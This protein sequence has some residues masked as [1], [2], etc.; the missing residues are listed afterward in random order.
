MKKDQKFVLMFIFI[1]IFFLFNSSILFPQAGRGKA[2]LSGE[3]ENEE[4]NSIP[5][6]KVVLQFVEN[7][8]VIRETTTNEKG[9]WAIA[10]LQNGHWRIKVTAQG[11][12]PTVKTVKV[13][14]I[15]RNPLVNIV[16]KKAKKEK[17]MK[18]A[19]GLELFE[20]GNQLFEQ[21]EYDKALE[22]YQA[23]LGKNPKLFQVHLSIGNCYREMRN[24]EKAMNEYQIVIEK[25]NEEKE[26]EREVKAKAIAGIG[27]CYLMQDQ[28]DKAQQYF[29]KSLELNPKDEILAYNVGEIYFSHQ[30]MN[31]AIKYYKMAAE[32][33]PDWSDP[34]LR[35]GYAY[36]NKKDYENAAQ[37]FRKFLELEPDT[38][39]TASVKEI[40]EY[41]QKIK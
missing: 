6:A 31:Q 2:R 24:F 12:I 30:K 29:Q 21:E 5:S 20:K 33:K 8:N 13:S 26:K 15:S 36:L 4:G 39:R 40:L 32:I 23:F 1:L 34:Y 17:M 7:E 41:I 10:G 9:K 35:M 38:Q 19:L 3:V 16:L 27:E 18:E 28:L 14:E 25:A 37:S 11:Y 22:Q